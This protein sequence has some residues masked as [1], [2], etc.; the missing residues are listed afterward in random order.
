MFVIMIF[1]YQ[2]SQ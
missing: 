1:R 2:R